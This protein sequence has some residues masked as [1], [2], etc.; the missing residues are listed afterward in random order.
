VEEGEIE[1]KMKKIEKKMERKE[2]EKRR[3][4]IVIRE[5]VIKERKRKKTVDEIMKEIGI[6]LKVK[7]IMENRRGQRKRRETIEIKV[8]EKDKRKKIWE[9]RGE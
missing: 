9:K 4:N 3:K 2:R 6:E 7:K 8:K 1:R 5:I